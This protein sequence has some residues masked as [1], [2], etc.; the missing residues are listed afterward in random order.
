M[1]EVQRERN[2]ARQWIFVN[3]PRIIFSPRGW[4]SR[5]VVDFIR[6]CIRPSSATYRSMG[7][8]ITSDTE[9]PVCLCQSVIACESLLP[10]PPPPFLPEVSVHLMY[11][12]SDC[13]WLARNTR[14]PVICRWPNNLGRCMSSRA[15]SPLGVAGEWT[16]RALRWLAQELRTMPIV[17]SNSIYPHPRRLPPLHCSLVTHTCANQRPLCSV[18]LWLWVSFV[19][20]MIEM[21][22][23]WIG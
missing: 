6:D 3:T 1:L 10:T 17:N 12:C 7:R 23:V 2:V 18:P 9:E 22:Y 19:Y 21:T 11:M 14:P 13:G 20:R 8:R 15:L 4:F 5:V 16:C